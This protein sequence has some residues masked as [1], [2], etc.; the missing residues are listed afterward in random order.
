MKDRAYKQLESKQSY[1]KS[2]SYCIINNRN[3]IELNIQTR[4]MR[5]YWN[6]KQSFSPQQKNAPSH[7]ADLISLTDLQSAISL[8]F[9][10]LAVG[11][12]TAGPS[13]ASIFY[14]QQ[15]AISRT[16]FSGLQFK[17]GLLVLAVFFSSLLHLTLTQATLC[18]HTVYGL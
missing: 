14:S 9:S 15:P 6:E 13:A 18:T 10:W 7:A 1:S 2:P 4:M 16:T 8:W 12:M 3:H 5:V 17:C 11:F